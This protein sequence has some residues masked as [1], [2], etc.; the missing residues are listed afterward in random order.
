M[1]CEDQSLSHSRPKEVVAHWILQSSSLSIRQSSVTVLPRYLK[2]CTFARCVP[3][4]DNGFLTAEFW[5]AMTSVFLQFIVRP[6]EDAA[7]AKLSMWSCNASSESAISAQSSAYWN[8]CSKVVIHLDCDRRRARLK[9]DPFERKRIDTPEG[10]SE[11][12][13]M[14]IAAANMAKRVGARMHPCLTPLL[15]GISL[16]SSLSTKI[17]TVMSRCKHFRIATNLGG[18]PIFFMMTHRALRFTE[19][20]ALV[21]STKAM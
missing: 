11:K 10:E 12:A 9:S 14:N 2:E 13:C 16:V 7:S 18:H 17:L 4:T 5:S 15:Y 6:N 20:N 21:K 1:S 3:L 8:S 19:S